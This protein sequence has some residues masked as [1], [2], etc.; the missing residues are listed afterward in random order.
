MVKDDG[1]FL[2]SDSTFVYSGH[3]LRP[4]SDRS[5]WD[6]CWY[7]KVVRAW[8]VLADE[9]VRT[10]TTPTPPQASRTHRHDHAGQSNMAPAP[11]EEGHPETLWK[12]RRTIFK[13]VPI[14][15]DSD[16]R[17][18]CEFDRLSGQPIEFDDYDSDEDEYDVED[19]IC[20]HCGIMHSPFGDD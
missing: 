14:R 15:Q 17:I 7:P 18:W 9:Y 5:K 12:E 4:M 6:P 2:K 8:K 13:Q 1:L 16:E 10:K 11:K 20:L 19:L 3:R